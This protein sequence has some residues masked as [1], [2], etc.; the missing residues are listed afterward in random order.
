MIHVRRVEIVSVAK[1][2]IEA[3]MDPVNTKIFLDG[4]ELTGVRSVKYE[5]VYN[6][7]PLITLE[8]YG[9]DVEFEGPADVEIVSC[10]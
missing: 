9:N 4:E 6:D 2:R 10:G 3:D 1:I 7:H 8:L 5:I